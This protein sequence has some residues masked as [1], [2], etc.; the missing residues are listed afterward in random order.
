[1][2]R[3]KKIRKPRV[4]AT[5]LTADWYWEQDASLRFTN[6]EVQP[7]A[8][9]DPNY[10]RLVLGKRRW[11]TGLQT[12]GG[13]DAHRALLDARLPFRDF[14]AWREGTR[15]RL[16]EAVQYARGLRASAAAN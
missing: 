15:M 8:G 16:S 3:R 12:E 1:L 9:I 11:E 7:G 10:A 14:V 5:S 6:V 2:D 13:W 4:I